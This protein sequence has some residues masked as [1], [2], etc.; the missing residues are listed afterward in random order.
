MISLWPSL[1]A[2]PDSPYAAELRKDPPEARFAAP[3]EVQFLRSRLRED[4]PLVRLTCTLALLLMALRG[5]E[6]LGLVLSSRSVPP[7]F[8]LVLVSS[9]ALAWLSW[10][11]WYERLYLPWA[12]VLVPLRNCLVAAQ[13]IHLAAQGQSDILMVLPMLLIG[14]FYFLGLLY[15]TALLTAG[16]TLASLAGA[17]AVFHLSPPMAVRGGTF[18]IVSVVVLAIAARQIEKRLR[19]AFLENRV[20]AELAQQ[21]ALTWTKNRRVFD[22]YLPRLWR[23]AVSDERLLAILVIDVDHF[24]SYN[25]RYGH[26]AGDAVLRRVAIA[27]QQQARRPLDLVARYGGE[28]FAVILY[29][30]DGAAARS[31]AERMRQAVE[32][33]AIEH[34][35]S[36]SG[37]VLTISVGVAVVSPTSGRNAFGALQL[38]DEALYRAKAAGRNRIEMRDDTE[39]RMLVTGVFSNISDEAIQEAEDEPPPAPELAAPGEGSLP[40]AAEPG[41]DPP[42][43][44][45]VR[46]AAARD[47]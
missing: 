22:E 4:R 44:A 33:L 43:R 11:R 34:C 20:V 38:A 31:T 39:Y 12:A 30:I 23:Q 13:V 16:L 41:E 37:G 25:D 29:D 45:A 24:K 7:L 2:L 10:S 40:P 18:L 36:P 1:E 27:L 21:D 46:E 9:L 6:S 14:P 32:Q 47:R 19:R 5:G 3:V 35:G 28:E 15:R 17:A 8:M 26:Q 42:G